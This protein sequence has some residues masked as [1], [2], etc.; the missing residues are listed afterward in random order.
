[1]DKFLIFKKLLIPL[2]ITKDFYFQELCLA[3]GVIVIIFSEEE[4]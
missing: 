1:M 4:L 2:D 3:I